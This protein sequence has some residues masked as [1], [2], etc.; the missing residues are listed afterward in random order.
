VAVVVAE[1]GVVVAEAG[2]VVAVVVA[3]IDAPQVC[4]AVG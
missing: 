2:A 1:A 3:A 4:R